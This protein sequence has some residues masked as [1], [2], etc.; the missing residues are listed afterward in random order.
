M[1]HGDGNH[2][3]IKRLSSRKKTLLVRLVDDV[4]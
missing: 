1:D 4:E 2:G 3:Q